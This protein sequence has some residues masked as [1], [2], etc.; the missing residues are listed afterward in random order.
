MTIKTADIQFNADG[1]PV[2]TDFDDVYFSSSDG[3]QE[4]QY[5]FLHNNQLQSRWQHWTK[6]TFVIAETGFGTGLNL[7]VTLAAFKD[8]LA[9]NPASTFTLHF[10]STEKYPLSHTDLVQALGAFVQFKDSANALIAQYPMPLNGCHRMAFLNNRVI[11]DLWL[12]DIHDSLPQWQTNESGLVD[13]WYLDGFAPSK[14]PQMWSTQLFEQMARL[15]AKDCTFA[16]FTAAG[17]VKRGLRDAGFV[18]EKRKGHGRKREMLAGYIAPESDTQINRQQARYYQ[19]G[20]YIHPVDESVNKAKCGHGLKPKVAI[21]GAGI[22]GAT[23]AYAMAQ[24]G[25]HCD[26]YFKEAEPAQGASGNPQAGF[27]P[28]L[29]VDASNASQINAHSF[30]YAANQYRQLLS[31]GFGFAHQWCGVL[32]LGFKPALAQRYAKLADNQ[33]WP[34]ALVRYV[35]ANEA[36]RL[37]NCEIPYGGL[38]MPLGGWIDPAQ[39]VTALFNAAAR[40]SKVTLHSHHCLSELEQKAKSSNTSPPQPWQLRFNQTANKAS[41]NS[42]EADIVI[43]ATGAQSHELPHL[44]DYPLRMVRGQVEAIPT[45]PALSELNTVLCHKGYLTPEYNGQHALGSTYV[46][47]D[48][49]TEYRHSEQDKN[50]ATHYQSLAKCNWAQDVVGNA[51]GRAAVRCSS[52]DHLP[53]VGALAD[54]RKQKTELNDL[55]K[56]LPLNYYPKAS[57]M[58]NLFMLTGLGSRG[59]TTAPLMAEVLASQ[60]SGHPLPLAN[61]LLNALNPNRF[62]IRQLIRREI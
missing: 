13:A 52:P 31:Q 37:A 54:I 60:I 33:L 55:Y 24:K 2:A 30:I 15:A 19:R 22:A 62:L 35:E 16:T 10:I 43:Y 23:T 18:V 3:A 27:Y 25:Y 5:V 26:V 34:P 32:Q 58:Q 45:Q 1:T 44:T 46:K 20:A 11:V 7:L 12:G 29:N 42:V 49:N 8:Y 56:A 4:T 51:H 36:S 14:N 9:Q 28:Q 41:I 50:L 59:L 38:F 57:D 47:D 39:L 17:F 61:D 48:L 21:I 6:P 53:L 40:L